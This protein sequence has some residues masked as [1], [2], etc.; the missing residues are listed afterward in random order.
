MSEYLR[1]DEETDTCLGSNGSPLTTVRMSLAYDSMYQTIRQIRPGASRVD[2]I[3]TTAADSDV[4]TATPADLLTAISM[5]L[6][7]RES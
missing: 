7:I 2:L 5:L 1:P 3:S 6:H 4:G